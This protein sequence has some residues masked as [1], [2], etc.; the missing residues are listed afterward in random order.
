MSVSAPYVL[1][2]LQKTGLL[3]PVGNGYVPAESAELRLD[4]ADVGGGTFKPI[5][6]GR[7]PTATATS[8]TQ[9]L[10]QRF[11]WTAFGSDWKPTRIQ[12]LPGAWDDRASLGW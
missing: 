5:Y 11:S 6:V 12:V 10:I 9:W 7:A 2:D 1:G 3:E 4:F 8:S